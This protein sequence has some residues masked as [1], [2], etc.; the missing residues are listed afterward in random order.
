V[1]HAAQRH[2]KC[3]RHHRS[4][5]GLTLPS[6]G[7]AFGVRL[8]QTLGQSRCEPRSY[9][10]SHSSGRRPALRYPM[11]VNGKRCFSR[12]LA[13]RL[14]IVCP[15]SRVATEGGLSRSRSMSRWARLISI[16]TRLLLTPSQAKLGFAGTEVS[17][18][19]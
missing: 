10:L 1:G 13:R 6:S 18:A 7:P 2:A 15:R 5:S 19:P 4:S 12:S 11:P 8:S 3:C 16:S 9:W 14:S 17:L